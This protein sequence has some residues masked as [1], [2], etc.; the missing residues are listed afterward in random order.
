MTAPT[1]RELQH[2][3]ETLFA[4]GGAPGYESRL[5]RAAPGLPVSGDERLSAAERISIYTGMIFVRIRD[6]IAEDFVAT[7]SALGEAA[8][9][10]TLADYLRAHPT[11]HPDL[12]MAARFL[13]GFLRDTAARP[14]A[15]LAELEW[16]L[17]DAFTAQDTAPLRAET[18]QALPA[19]GWPSLEIRA[20]PS[21]RLL[22][23]ASPAD[24]NRREI[25]DGREVTLGTEPPFPLRIWRRDLR[26]FHKRIGVLERDALE[27]TVEGIS[28]AALCEWLAEAAPDRDPSENAV[29]LLQAW[30]AEELLAAPK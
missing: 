9:E 26:V 16:A 29:E 13:P 22:E 3:L 25:L 6:A 1:L 30:L 23:P 15:D 19:N 7:R 21:L 17:L 18:L 8:W 2:E 10:A 27:R 14:I 28:F 12:R 5:E 4:L 24:R 11:D 20:V